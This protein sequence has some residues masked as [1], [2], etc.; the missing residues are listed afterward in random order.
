MKKYTRFAAL[1]LSVVLIFSM[2][3]ICF[4]AV[5]DTGFADVDASAWYGSPV[6]GSAQA[7]LA[8]L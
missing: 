7:P 6:S 2:M 8:P 3:N 4:A 5:E 1:L